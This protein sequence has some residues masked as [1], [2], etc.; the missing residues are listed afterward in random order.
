MSTNIHF[1]KMQGAGNDYIYVDTSAYHIENPEDLARKWSSLHTGIGSDGLV[2]IGNSDRADF[3]IRFF[4]SDG[5]EAGMCGNASRCIG[6]YLFE[7]KMTDKTE[8]TLDTLSGIKTV[9]LH[10]ENGKV[11]SV[12]TDMGE[13]IFEDHKLFRPENCGGRVIPIDVCGVE[14]SGTFISMGNPHFVIFVDDI[15]SIDLNVLGPA[16]EHC[17][18]FP[19]RVNAEFAQLQPDGAIRMRVWERGSG[20]TMSCG[21]GACATAVAATLRKNAGR[22]SEILT[23]GGRLFVEWSAND[24]H[25]YLSGPAEKVFEGDIEI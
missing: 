23:D 6:K 9:R 18:L 3:G 15:L 17:S 22:E 25:V 14:I 16:I 12:T 4:N 24:N 2:L 11:A 7:N 1:T 21:T 19:E 8:I 13:P 5:S 20:V 10:I